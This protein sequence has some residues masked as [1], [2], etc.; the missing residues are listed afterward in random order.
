M[1]RRGQIL[2]LALLLLQQVAG[3]ALDQELAGQV[4]VVVV[5][6]EILS[7]R[8]ELE[9]R[10]KAITAARVLVENLITLVVV[11]E[12]ALLVGL[13]TQQLVEQALQV[14]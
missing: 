11:E 9:L 13:E 12:K 1:D 3:L 5:V 14:Q 10:D 6:V 7:A 8:V 2:L 4:E